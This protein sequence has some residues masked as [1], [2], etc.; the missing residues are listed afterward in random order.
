MADDTGIYAVISG[1]IV[2]S[3]RF[4]EKGPAVRDA[5]KSAHAKCAEAFVDA[6]GGLPGV[7]VFAGDSWQMLVASPTPALRIG[8]CMRALLKADPELPDADSRIA[9]GIGGA[10]FIDHEN[11]SVSQG[12]AFRLS[13]E[14]LE[15]LRDDGLRLA[16]ALPE[17][18]RRRSN[19]LDVQATID[20]MM[21]LVDSL[22][23][24]W[25]AHQAS[26]VA[27]ALMGRT[28]VST[29]DELSITQPAVSQALSAAKWHE[30][31]AVLLW[32]E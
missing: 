23:R 13:G 3:S 30:L 4:M 28:Q 9:I 31:E 21:V 10:E 6:L 15:R 18:L 17:R 16:V 22:C 24:D 19:Q 8:L 25:T 12:E 1:D 11:L 32:W 26:V 14:A 20:T 2:G 27:R 5:I 7:D 29:A